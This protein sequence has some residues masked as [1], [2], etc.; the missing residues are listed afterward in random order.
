M[1]REEDSLVLKPW[2]PKFAFAFCEPPMVAPWTEWAS[3]LIE[4][5]SLVLVIF[6][7]WL[8]FQV[9]GEFA[10]VVLAVARCYWCLSLDM[11]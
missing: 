9:F 7:I 4:L 1:V 3:V 2:G 8:S 6:G 10:F 11:D 5:L